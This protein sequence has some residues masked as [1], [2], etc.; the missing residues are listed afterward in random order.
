MTNDMNIFELAKL[1]HP[2][3][4]EDAISA[5]FALIDAGTELAEKVL[6]LAKPLKRLLGQLEE[7]EMDAS[8]SETHR[9]SS[10][11]V[12]GNVSM[13]TLDEVREAMGLAPLAKLNSENK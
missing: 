12:A 13:K 5:D 10:F 9:D 11:W 8:A 3:R 4:E 6:A 7:I 2:E 1:F